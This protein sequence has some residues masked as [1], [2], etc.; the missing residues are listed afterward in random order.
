MIDWDFKNIILSD[1]DKAWIEAL[2]DASFELTMDIDWETM[3]LIPI[4]FPPTQYDKGD[5]EERFDMDWEDLD[6][7]NKRTT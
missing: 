6:D 7:S 3:E 1:R 5:F 4:G 2:Q